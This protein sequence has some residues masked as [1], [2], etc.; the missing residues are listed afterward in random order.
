GDLELVALDRRRA[1]GG[2]LAVVAEELDAIG[3]PRHPHRE[4]D[5]AAHRPAIDLPAAGE[6]A[7]FAQIERRLFDDDALVPIVLD[8]MREIDQDMPH[9]LPEM[10]AMQAAAFGNGEFGEHS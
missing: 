7:V 9:A 8:R 3:P 5:M 1:V 10:I 2:R 6:R 4:M